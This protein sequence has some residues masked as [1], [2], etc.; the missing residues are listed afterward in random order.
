MKNCLEAVKEIDKLPDC[1]ITGIS[2][3]YRTEPVGVD[4]Q[5]WYVNGVVSL[6]IRLS[7]RDLMRSLLAIE[8]GMGRVRKD[9]WESRIIDLDILLYAD[10]VIHEE[11]LSVPHPLMSKRRFVMAPMTELAPDLKH[12]VLHRRMIELLQEIPN[13]EQVVKPV[14]E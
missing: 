4:G 13:G 12:P 2:K 1:K 8:A 3:W 9:K 5:E 11:D 10:E 7:A 6:S 14:K